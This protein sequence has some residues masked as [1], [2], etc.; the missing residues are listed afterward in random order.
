MKRL[1]IGKQDFNNL[2]TSD[3]IYVDKTEYLLQLIETTAPIFLS[4]PRRFGKSLM[5]TTFR[6]LFLGNKDL[7]QRTYAYYHW[8]FEKTHPVLHLDLSL[9]RGESK[10]IISEKLLEL[11]Y[12]A[13]EDAGISIKETDN[14]DIALS[15]LIR[16]AGQ[17]TRAVIL[18]D[19]YDTP[20]LDNLYG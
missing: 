6:E 16:K 19:E 13:A 3:C 7:F 12:N 14:P 17:E 8:D 15:R 2:I 5:V 4:R 11:V 20:I 1:P 10:E 18:I 9:V